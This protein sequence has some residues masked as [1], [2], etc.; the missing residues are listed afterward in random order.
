MRFPVALTALAAFLSLV[1]ACAS[2]LQP[3]PSSPGLSRIQ[4]R[5]EV[6]VGT[7]AS[8]PPLNMTTRKGRSSD[9]RS[10]WRG[11]SPRP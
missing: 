5:G 10:T 3:P 9:S 8:M 1:A 6:V 7:A 2:S 4:A 11:A